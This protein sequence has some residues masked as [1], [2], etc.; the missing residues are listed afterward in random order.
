MAVLIA[1]PEQATQAAS[2]PSSPPPSPSTPP[3]PAPAPADQDFSHLAQAWQGFSDDRRKSLL[4]KMSSEQKKGLR[5]VLEK[6]GS[7]SPAAASTTPLSDLTTQ[8]TDTAPEGTYMMFG[9]TGKG[10]EVGQLQIPYSNVP[11]AQQQGYTFYGGSAATYAKDKAAE[12]KTPTLWGKIDE[13]IT[14]ALQP[15][16]QRTDK[17][18]RSDINNA[19]RAAGR[20]VYGTP[21]YVRDVAVAYRDSLRTGNTNELVDL[22]DPAQLPANLLHQ[23]REDRQTDPRLAVQNLVGSIIGAGTVSA[24]THGASKVAR[25]VPG[26]VSKV[27]SAAGGLVR[28]AAGIRPKTAADLVDTA[29]KENAEKVEVAEKQNATASEQHLEKTQEALHEQAGRETAHTQAVKAEAEKIRTKEAT[30]AAKRQAEHAEAAQKADAARA[31]AQHQAETATTDQQKEFFRKKAEHQ[32]QVQQTEAENARL[33]GEHAQAV[34]GH[35]ELQ[36]RLNQTDRAAKVGL[37]ALEKNV[38]DAASAEYADLAPK[39]ASYPADPETMAAVVD[40]ARDSIDPA[41]GEPPLF[42]KLAKVLKNKQETTYADLDSFRS[43][44]NTTLRK[45]QVPGSTYHIY[46]NIMEPVIIDEM[47]R[48]ASDHGLSAEAAHARASWRTWAE[49]FRDRASPLRKVLKDPEAHGTLKTMRGKQSYLDRL[50]KFGPEG[51]ALA[52]QIDQHLTEAQQAKALYSTYGD[53]KVPAPKP[54]KLEK[55]PE[56]KEEVPEPVEA[57]PAAATAP[58]TKP[59][60]EL[61]S[62]SPEERAAQTVKQPDRPAFPDRPAEVRPEFRKLGPEDL[63]EANRNQYLQTVKKLR[64]KGIFYGAVLPWLWVAKDLLTMNLP[65]AALNT[66]GAAVSSAVTAAGVLKLTD[67]LEKPEIIEWIARPSAK[68]I[69]K[70][71]DL[72]PEQRRAV[73]DGFR[74]VTA[75]AAKKGWKVSPLI[76]AFIAASN[77]GTTEEKRKKQPPEPQPEEDLEGALP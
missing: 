60:L 54:P 77:A 21:G 75:V 51:E 48:I 67:H 37:R 1:D 10:E 49:S 34:A 7:T 18:A 66:I 36:T 4:G 53:I 69:A 70:L 42:T 71:N 14:H 47:D 19:L 3:A 40:D 9:R 35:G 11:K 5:Q 13:R 20:T 44:I 15:E 62:G 64:E 28:E 12:G 2:V 17:P 56:F 31:A 6:A 57:K 41:V 43:A 58:P 72:P 39:L 16:P 74:Q 65:K 63:M 23:Y 30:E 61:T 29:M 59:P 33:E 45:Q 25:A 46:R 68:D 52:G 27:P 50:R 32:Q 73:A 8:P 22:L 26:V 76:G 24:L 38:H 55:V